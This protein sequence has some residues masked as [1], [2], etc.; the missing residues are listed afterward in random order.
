[1]A[2][3]AVLQ[4]ILALVVAGLVLVVPLALYRYDYV[5]NKR[6][7]VVAPGKLYRSG[8]MTEAGFKA[9]VERYGL[10]VIINLQDEYPDP[11]IDCDYFGMSTIKESEMCRRLGVRY[12][13]MPPQLI[14]RRAVSPQRPAAIDRFLEIMDDAANH[15]VLLHCRAGL[16]RTGVMVEVYRQEYEGCCAREA[17]R[18]LKDNGFGEWP[19]SAA[20]DYIMQYI[21]TYRP[22]LRLKTEPLARGE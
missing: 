10:R 2:K 20:N 3:P 12:L 5:E 22:G 9:A 8:Q 15:P 16:H 19:C 17:I 11:D 1:V 18:D 7:R 14:S 4:W 13:W 21:L 6:L